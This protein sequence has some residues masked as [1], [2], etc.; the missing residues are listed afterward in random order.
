MSFY[1]WLGQETEELRAS[2]CEILFLPVWTV[3]VIKM[4]HVQVH[5]IIDHASH[6]NA[7]APCGSG[8]CCCCC[9]HL[10]AT[11][12]KYYISFSLRINRIKYTRFVSWV[13]SVATWIR[14]ANTHTHTRTPA[15]P[16]GPSNLIPIALCGGNWKASLA[17]CRSFSVI[18]HEKRFFLASFFLSLFL[19]FMLQMQKGGDSMFQVRDVC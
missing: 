17:V 19:F 18:T 4:D 7:Y 11:P 8:G 6:T 15:V 10:M 13:P 3:V 5:A 2:L 14:G 9:D 12:N 1:P 16:T